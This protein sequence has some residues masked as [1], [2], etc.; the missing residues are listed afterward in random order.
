MPK[1]ISADKLKSILESDKE[2]ALLDVRERNEYEQGQIFGATQVPRRSLEIRI[3]VLIPVKNTKIILYDEDNYRALLAARTLES[4]GYTNIYYLAGGLNAWKDAGYP[5]VKGVHVLSKSFGEIVGEIR[6]LVPVILPEDLKPLYDEH[7]DEYIILEVRPEEEVQKTGSIPGAINISGVELPLRIADYAKSG[8]TII[9][10]C[11]GRTRGFIACATLKKQGIDKVYDLNNGTLGWKLAGFD[12]AREIP[13]GPQPSAESRKKAD[14]F[15]AEL[16]QKQKLSFITADE[17]AARQQ[18]EHKETVYIVDVRSSAEYESIGHIPGAISIPG[19]QAI[20]NTDDIV[21]V[22][23]ATVVFVCDNATRSIIT[24]YWYR[25]MGFEKV[26]VLDGG[27]T[28]WTNSGHA[29]ERGNLSVAPLCFDQVFPVVAKVDAAKLQDIREEHPNFLVIDVSDS[30]SFANGHIPGAKWISQGW[31]EKRIESVV[32]DK[33]TFFVV[34]GQDRYSHIFAALTL[35]KLGFSNVSAL[36]GGNGSW[37]KS[38]YLLSYGLE[39][40]KPDDWHVHLTEYGQEEAKR[41]FAW[42]ESLV[43]LP[44]YMDYFRRKGIL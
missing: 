2:Y 40:I 14:Q 24:A 39:G 10:T 4:Y 36:D 20:Q 27:L 29:L 26:Y 7:P 17:L 8:K 38:G 18:R 6:K 3:S 41:Y 12:L 21:A 25:E 9:T 23:N 34:T 35:I 32:S 1:K 22:H 5:L 37:V 33:E 30:K 16:A 44:E 31:L 13:Q 28:E 15:A 19:G 11:A 43:H 42:E